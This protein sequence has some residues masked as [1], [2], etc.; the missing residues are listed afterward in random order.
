M[1]KYW[2]VEVQLHAFLFSTLHV[3]AVLIVVKD[4]PIPIPYEAG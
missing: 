2:Y 1:K 4:L 3:P